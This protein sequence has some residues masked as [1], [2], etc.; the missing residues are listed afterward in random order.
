MTLLWPTDEPI[1][2]EYNK[3][4]EPQYFEWRGQSYWVQHIAK[5]WRL[6]DGWWQQH[7]WREYF[8]LTTKNGLLVIIFRD[9]ITGQ[10][11]LQRLYD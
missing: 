4:L 10:W 9:L 2:V 5:R 8:K 6:D 7:T 11:Y 1:L 3:L